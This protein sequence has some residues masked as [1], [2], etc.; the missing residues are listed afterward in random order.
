MAAL[1]LHTVEIAPGPEGAVRAAA[2]LA[3]RMD[4]T[5][6]AFAL[7]PSPS[8]HI[9]AEYVAMIRGALRLDVP[10]EDPD[11]ALVAATSGSTGIP[12]G[13]ALTRANLVAAVEASWAHVPGLRECSWVIALPVASIGG[14]GAIVRS[15]LSGTRLHILPT[16]G[17]AAPFR[18]RDLLDLDVDESFA[19]SLVPSQVVDILGSA[20]TTS[21]LAR[22]RAVL[23]GAAATPDDVADRA[24]SAGIRLITTYGMTETTGGC[25]YDGVPLPGCLLECDADGRVLVTGPQVASGYHGLPDETERAFRGIAP[26]R[27]FRTGDHGDWRDGRLRIRGRV[28]D[29][30]TVHGVNV[31]LG[32]VESVIRSC[33]GVRDVAVVAV[34]DPRQG[35]RLIAYVTMADPAGLPAVAP[36]VAE[37][38]GGAA[39]PAV[40]AMDELPHLPNGKIDRLALRARAAGR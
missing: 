26:Q 19:I 2:A 18:A 31:A 35:H 34:E 29:V 21:W 8:R 12:R 25:A 1:P 5:G 7:V 20:E 37:Q 9:S 40:V 23:V 11:T 3:E 30:V 15:L 6:A 28:D 4:G 39:R 10:L 17:G 33:F 36:Y 22:A 27:T 13:V 24:L 16:I 38:L 32:A 14:F